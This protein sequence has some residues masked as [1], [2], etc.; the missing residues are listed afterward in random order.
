MLARKIEGKTEHIVVRLE[1][2][3]PAAVAA[4]S[5]RRTP[6]FVRTTASSGAR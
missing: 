4:V 2:V 6:R 5:R 3:A 1:D